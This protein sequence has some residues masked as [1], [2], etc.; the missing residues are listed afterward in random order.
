MWEF[1]V[2]VDEM[3]QHWHLEKD[4]RSEHMSAAEASSE[5]DTSQIQT[6]VVQHPLFFWKLIFLPGLNFTIKIFLSLFSLECFCAF[7][8]YCKV[9]A[10]KLFNLC[11]SMLSSWFITLHLTGCLFLLAGLHTFAIILQ[12]FTFIKTH[13]SNNVVRQLSLLEYRR[14]IVFQREWYQKYD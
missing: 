3:W 1:W 13:Y 14:V 12:C 4:T 9:A 2:K 5:N 8:T 11:I 10:L 6:L 7:N